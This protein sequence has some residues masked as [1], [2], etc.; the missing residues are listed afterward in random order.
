MVP[1][2]PGLHLSLGCLQDPTRKMRSERQGASLL[3]SARRPGPEVLRSPSPHVLPGPLPALRWNLADLSLLEGPSDQGIRQPQEHRGHQ[4]GPNLPGTEIAKGGMPQ[5]DP[6]PGPAQNTLLLAPP[7]GWSISSPSDLVDQPAQ[8]VP[9]PQL[10]H[11]P[12]QERGHVS[13][14]GLRTMTPAGTFYSPHTLLP[15]SPG[16]PF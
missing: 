13:L 8:G 9:G 3:S 6:S 2:D 11:H 16:A 1:R 7:R 10:Q 15:L 4:G 12:C 14:R 5:Q